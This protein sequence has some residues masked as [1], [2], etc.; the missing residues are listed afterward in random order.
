MSVCL[1]VSVSVSSLAGL[2]NKLCV[3]FGATLQRH[4]ASFTE[5]PIR[6]WCWSG[7]SVDSGSLCV[8]F[9]ISRIPLSR[10]VC[11]SVHILCQFVCLSVCT[12]RHRQWHKCLGG[13]HWDDYI[14]CL[15]VC[16]CVSVCLCLFLSACMSLCV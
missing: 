10:S 2:L 14:G 8:I 15:S 16:L 6:F 11:M 12:S 4:W 13:L 3:E 1:S 7:V 5:E 9:F